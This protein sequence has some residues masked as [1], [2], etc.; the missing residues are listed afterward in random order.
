MSVLDDFLVTLGV[1]GQDI[2]LAQ[3]DKIRKKGKDLSKSKTTV[4]LAA[5]GGRGAGKVTPGKIIDDQ[6]SENE[7]IKNTRRRKTED[8]APSNGG[9]DNKGETENANKMSQAVKKFGRGA[10]RFANAA[11]TLSPTAL[12]QSI[13][14][15]LPFL[16]AV[17]SAAG[18]ALESAKSSTFGA[19][20]LAKRNAAM[21]YYGGEQIRG[22]SLRNQGALSNSEHAMFV[23]AVSGSMGKIQKPLADEINKLIGKKDTRALARAASG[24]WE[25]TGTD[26]GWIAS[27]MM[28]GTEGLPPSIRQKISAAMLKNFG[29]EIQGASGEQRT[30]QGR[31]AYYEN[32]QEKQTT[33]LADT[34]ASA[35]FVDATGKTVNSIMALND[36]LNDMQNAMVK[37]ASKMVTAISFITDTAMN[38]KKNPTIAKPP[39]QAGFEAVVRMVK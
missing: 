15:T 32:A 13:A 16:G 6:K 34:A 39:L 33:R 11:A 3:M 28:S 17:A 30:R 2:V 35:T 8:A 12:I 36:A 27:Q 26:K 24:D 22:R 14:S 25:S 10:D 20:E 7:K 1:K 19:Y 21:K 9:Q 23:A 18:G 5:K 4:D 31:A 37:G 38:S 29:G